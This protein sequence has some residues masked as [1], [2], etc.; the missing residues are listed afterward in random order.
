MNKFTIR[1]FMN[2]ITFYIPAALSPNGK[3]LAY[4]SNVTG[5]PQVWVGEIEKQ[6]SKMLFPKPI[7]NEKEKSPYVFQESLFYIDDNT[8]AITKDN[9]GNETTFIEIHYLKTGMIE[10]VPRGEG[11]DQISFVS[12]DKKKIYFE[13]NRDIPSSTGLYS[14]DLKSKK[15]E[16]IHVDQEIGSTWIKTSEYKGQHFFIQMKSNTACKLKAINLKTRKVTDIFTEENC[17]V[18]PLE[19]LKNDELLVLCNHQRQFLSLAKINLKTRE[20]KYLQKD[21]WDVEQALLTPDHKQLFV[22]KNIEGK[23][24][25]EHYQFPSMKKNPCKFKNNGVISNLIYSKPNH[26]LII[27]FMSA[28]EPKNFYRYNIK[29]KKVERL[30]DTWTSSIP[31]KELCMP[32]SV[33]FESQGKKIQSWLFL[34][35]NNTNKKCPVIIWP[36]GGPQAQERSQFRPILQFLVAEGFAVWAPNHHGS[37]GFGKDFANAI[38]RNWGTADLPDMINGIEWLKKSKLIDEKKICIMGGSYGG[39]MTLRSLTKIKNTFK[40]GVDIFGPS[41]LITFANSVPED[42][43]PFMD[44]HVG[45]PIKDKEMLYEQSPINSLENIECPLLVVQGGKD[46]RVVQAESD[47]VVEIMR[48][49]GKDVEYLVFEDEGHGFMKI[50]NELKAYETIAKF[51]KEKLK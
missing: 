21:S 44:G 17:L 13:S 34:P 50:D 10:S 49:L 24:T 18:I 48:K 19:L 25:L 26:E 23:S 28:T 31:E 14:Y 22:A 35:K 39:Y 16:L 6:V 29:Q 11:R 40:V 4:I 32:K 33:H 8:M 47:K 46:P 37:V 30:T 12:K 20:L 27:G 43:K 51:I 45:N 1:E 42:W 7:T 3:Q 38:N 41:D 2:R 9:H 36:H 15:V 5:A